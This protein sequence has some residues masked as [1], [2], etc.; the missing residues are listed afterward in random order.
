MKC[1]NCHALERKLVGPALKDI[2]RR[3]ASGDAHITANYLA[4]RIVNGSANAWGAVPMPAN[5]Q[6]SAEDSRRLAEW[7][8]KLR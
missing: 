2:G 5:P 7:L 8:L 1:L 6:V 3:Y 4:Q